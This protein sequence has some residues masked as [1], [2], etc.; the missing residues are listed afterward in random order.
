MNCI[1]KTK[2]YALCNQ[3]G[4]PLG[5]RLHKFVEKQIAAGRSTATM[6][7]REG[8]TVVGELCMCKDCYYGCLVLYLH[9]YL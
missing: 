6:T 5:P 4:T 8:A 2:D 1:D 9:K 7:V 3:D